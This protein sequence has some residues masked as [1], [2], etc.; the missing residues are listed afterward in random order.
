MKHDDA[1]RKNDGFTLL[2]FVPLSKTLWTEW[3]FIHDVLHFICR[4]ISFLVITI[5]S[6]AGPSLRLVKPIDIFETRK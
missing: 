6:Y 1:T 2:F 4:F 5:E 3:E